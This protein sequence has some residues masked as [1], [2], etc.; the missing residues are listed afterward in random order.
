MVSVPSDKTWYLKYE[1]SEHRFSDFQVFRSDFGSDLTHFGEG[2]HD[3]LKSS[4]TDFLFQVAG[5]I[6]RDANH[7]DSGPLGDANN[8]VERIFD[9][10]RIFREIL[11]EKS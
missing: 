11:I 8:F 4:N 3:F 2:R 6:A 1:I 5:F 7:R 10:L 9:I